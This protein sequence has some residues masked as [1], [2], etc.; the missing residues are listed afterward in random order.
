M[1]KK[2]RMLGM[3]ADISRRDF[4]NGVNVAMG[5]SLMPSSS[6]ALDIGKQDLRGYYPPQRTGTRGSHSGSF[7]VAHMALDGAH[8][9][10][11]DLPER[12][13]LIVVGSGISGLS[14]A[15]FYQQAAGD[16]A[17]ILIL[18]NHDDFSGHAKRNEFEIDGRDRC[19]I[20]CDD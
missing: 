11:E 1:N 5:A 14:A 10:A 12:Y 4:L 6:H 9:D 20:Q 17:N 15:Y 19:R 3:D 8:W 16:N 7:E 2:D 13:D 18:D